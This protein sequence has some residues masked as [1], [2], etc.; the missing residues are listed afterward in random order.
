M[1]QIGEPLRE[2]VEPADDPVVVPA[3]RP[4]PEVPAEPE[5]APV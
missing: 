5:P 3:E 2:W 4:A 1:G